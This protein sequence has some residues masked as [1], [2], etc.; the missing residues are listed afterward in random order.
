M[1]TQ[2]SAQ[3]LKVYVGEGD[4]YHGGPLY[5]A[6]VVRLREA[7]IAGVTVLHGTTAAYRTDRSLVSGLADCD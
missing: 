5:A 4:Q 7:G 6:L 1:K 2:Y 3:I